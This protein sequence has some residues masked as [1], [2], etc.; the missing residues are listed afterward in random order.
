MS[1]H[2]VNFFIAAI[3]VSFCMT[4]SYA[5]EEKDFVGAIK[6]IESKRLIVE[7]LNK[8]W[9]DIFQDR[10]KKIDGFME[11]LRKIST[12]ID[13]NTHYKDLNK[14]YDFVVD[15]WRAAADH[16]F[17]NISGTAFKLA[18]P[19]LPIV[20]LNGD[21]FT[22]EEKEHLKRHE[23]G[24]SEDIVK[25]RK[26]FEPFQ[27]SDALNYSNMLILMGKIRSSL[28]HIHKK[29]SVLKEHKFSEGYYADLRREI[30][31]I[32]VRWMAI[33]YSK[34]VEIQNHL[35]SGIEGKIFVAQEAAWLLLILSLIAAFIWAFQKI[36]YYFEILAEKLFQ[37][38]SSLNTHWF[39][40]FT[41]QIINK[42]IPW[43]TLLIG[44]KILEKFLQDTSLSEVTSLFSYLNI[45]IYYKFLNLFFI[46]LL[47]RL[48][49]LKE[50]TISYKKHIKI[51]QDVTTI[52]RVGFSIL[53]ALYSIEAIV[54]EVLM[55]DLAVK[56]ILFFVTVYSAFMAYGWRKELMRRALKKKI[57]GCRG[58]LFIRN[59]KYFSTLIPIF[60]F[61]FI[62]FDFVF[63]KIF[64]YLS[65]FNSF[66]KIHAFL[67]LE[68]LRN[69]HDCSE[70]AEIKTPP[71][72]YTECFSSETKLAGFVEE[73]AESKEAYKFINEWI[74]GN[75]TRNSLL[76]SGSKGAGKSMLLSHLLHESVG[77]EKIKIC[78][79]SKILEVSDLVGL[80][81]S[82]GI[83]LN[84]DNEIKSTPFNLST[85]KTIIFIEDFHNLYLASSPLF[86]AMDLFLKM[87][88]ESAQNI[89]WCLS[90]HKESWYYLTKSHPQVCIIDSVISLLPWS[91][92]EIKN[93][94]FEVHQQTKLLLN[95]DFFS[96]K[97]G[98]LKT[99]SDGEIGENNFF[100]ILR[101]MSDG[102]PI[103]A[104]RLW[105]S[106]IGYDANLK[107]IIVLRPPLFD[108]KKF[109]DLGSE[110]HFICASVHRHENLNK[111]Y[112][113]DLSSM[114]SN[115]VLK[116]I[117]E[118]EI[119]GFIVRDQN[120]N[121]FL[122]P[123]YSG[124]IVRSLR[125]KNHAYT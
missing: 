33:T 22:K 112:I 69:I 116:K 105:L 78:I 91:A 2:K 86:H 97:I 88:H 12:K 59:I 101:Q 6:Q 32:P 48:K 84:K 10:S 26:D 61:I 3:L 34:T 37:R 107:T 121:F 60:L 28:Y 57:K 40:P 16:S 103:I 35:K 100:E 36:V 38:L 23:E 74:L 56:I 118:A 41:V 21:T 29:S 45:Y 53:A 72:S 111:E 81:K 64:K 27:Q 55:Y 113:F 42:F 125:R 51:N 75:S 68:K 117:K 102:S 15:L 122:N 50:I 76:I 25:S 124:S 119:N 24:L 106:S 31:L 4:F 85:K 62:V 114:N 94:I 71:I 93:L 63:K 17:D 109:E 47:I 7:K 77:V 95:F 82:H 65:D 110:S 99:S 18:L 70:E 20:N 58:I 39:Y 98:A 8:E 80:L 96:K 120:Q 66:K 1:F 87:I 67:I 13:E 5:G 52:L 14:D 43:L 46:T 79:P 89:F 19:S 83:I 54:G 108:D 73:R 30:E 49:I 115:K 92:Y 44:I 104:V 11:K 90:C 9:K 123:I